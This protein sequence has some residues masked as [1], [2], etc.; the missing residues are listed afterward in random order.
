MSHTDLSAA[1][2]Q[3]EHTSYSVGGGAMLDCVIES[4]FSPAQKNPDHENGEKLF[5]G[6]TPQLRTT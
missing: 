2:F 5:N 3:V 1:L 4:W 6:L